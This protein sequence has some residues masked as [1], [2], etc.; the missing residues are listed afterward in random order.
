[1]EW[2][3]WGGGGGIDDVKESLCPACRIA[4][5]FFQVPGKRNVLEGGAKRSAS[6]Q[7]YQSVVVAYF[8]CLFVSDI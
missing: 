4:A 3:D 1:M 2:R 5:A 8:V 7:G 6:P